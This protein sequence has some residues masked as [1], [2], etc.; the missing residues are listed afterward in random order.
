MNSTNAAA[1]SQ[2]RDFFDNPN[3]TNFS[4]LWEINPNMAMKCL[5]YLLDE[6]KRE[7]EFIDIFT[8][9][10]YKKHN[11][12]F[13]RNLSLIV[14]IYNE[15]L[16]PDE[17]IRTIAEKDY[18]TNETYLNEYIDPNY[19]EPFRQEFLSRVRNTYFTNVVNLPMYGTVN[20]MERIQ[21]K[22]GD[23]KVVYYKIKKIIERVERLVGENTKPNSKS[24][25]FE[26]QYQ[27]VGIE[28]P[29]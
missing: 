6:R 21:Q 22:L 1:K 12:V 19:Q 10:I 23:D 14:G 18:D 25:K 3:E 13:H 16:I 15:Q 7:S 5:F 20:T 2:V 24:P 17:A 11:K 9:V 4:K 28:S 8:N 26:L 27:W 29:K